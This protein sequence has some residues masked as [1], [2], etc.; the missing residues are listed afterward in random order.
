[1]SAVFNILLPWPS[2]LFFF[3]T[4]IVLLIFLYW[5][6]EVVVHAKDYLT[7]MATD[8]K[9]TVVMIFSYAYLQKNIVA[10]KPSVVGPI[11]IVKSSLAFVDVFVWTMSNG[12]VIL[13][14]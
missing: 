14:N 8:Y 4:L 5:R 11:V 7:L 9:W 2:N 6:E 1:M 10:A 3:N 12:F 13:D